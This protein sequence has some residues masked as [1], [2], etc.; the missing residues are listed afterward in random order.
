MAQTNLY[1]KQEIFTGMVAGVTMVGTGNKASFA[2][3]QPVNIVR[4]GVE[5]TVAFTGAPVIALDKR[6]IVGSDTGRVDGTTTAG[7][8]V[9]GGTLTP[10]TL[11]IGKGAYREVNQNPGPFKLNPGEEAVFEVTTAATAGTGIFFLEYEEEGFTGDPI[12][13]SLSQNRIANMTKKSS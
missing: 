13:T 6:P 10:G 9:A 12:L 11:A 7:V 2:P 8:D 4:W 3:S 5:A 1:R